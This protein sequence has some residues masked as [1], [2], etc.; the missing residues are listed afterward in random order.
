MQY[1]YTRTIEMTPAG[2]LLP[3]PW[4]LGWAGRIG[5]AAGL[6]ALAAAVASAAA[7]FLWLASVLLP[8]AIIAAAVAYV[9]F[10]LQLWRL[11]T[12]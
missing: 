11:R 7:L 6:V 12:G 2:D 8:I 9:A 3:R 1:R 5:I 4:R 10:R